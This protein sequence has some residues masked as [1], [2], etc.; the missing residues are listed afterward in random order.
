[1][2]LKDWAIEDD[3]LNREYK[4]KNFVQAVVFLNKTVNPIEENQSYPRITLA[5][6][7]VKV[8]LFTNEA[9]AITTQDFEMAGQLDAIAGEEAAQAARIKA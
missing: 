4:F 2:G 8:S 9:G 5:Y 7:R 1:M 6:N 3:R